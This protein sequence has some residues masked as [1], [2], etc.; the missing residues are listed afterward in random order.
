MEAG[1]KYADV[2]SI[3]DIELQTGDKEKL[4]LD[5]N[6][7]S[8][9]EYRERVN[10]G[11]VNLSGKIKTVDIQA[12]LRA[13]HT[14][15]VGSLSVPNQTKTRDYLNW[16]PSFFVS[17]PIS[18]KQTLLLSYSYRIDRPNYQKLNPARGFIDLYAYSQ[19]NIGLVPQY[20]HAVELRY[21]LKSG[22]FASLAANYITD[23]TLDINYV[24]EGNKVVR[25][26]QNMGNSQ[27]YVVTLGLPIT[28]AKSWQAQASLL[29][30]YDQFQFEYEEK[31]LSAKN[32]AARLNFNNGF[33]LGRGW[34][35]ELNGWVNSPRVNTIMEIPWLSNVDVG[36]QK[37][38]SQKMKLKLSLQNVFFTPVVKNIIRSVNSYQTGLLQM[39]TRI[40]LL[41]LTY[42]FGNQKVKAARQRRTGA[43]DESR[44]A[45]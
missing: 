8:H 33:V 35:A 24:I 27:G 45:N 15:S 14:H 12:G 22:F 1:V 18:A 34:T 23:L 7:S 13:E 6:L 4:V 44:R 11:Y 20:T 26:N 31:K 10:A 40:L 9:F 2:N 3:N 37:S 25:L 42:A 32:V 36:V 38:V 16:F 39:D 41:N 19:G 43:E 29:G 28:V 17:K 21:A 5:P 30:F